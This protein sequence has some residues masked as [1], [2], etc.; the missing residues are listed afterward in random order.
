MVFFR[1][2]DVSAA[3]P[4]PEPITCPCYNPPINLRNRLRR[5]FKLFRRRSLRSIVRGGLR[6][7]FGKRGQRRVYGW[8]MLYKLRYEML[9][10][11]KAPM[12]QW[13]RFYR[14]RVWVDREVFP[15]IESLLLRAKHSVFIQMFIWKD[16]RVGRS[17]AETL[18]W[19]ADRGVSVNI[20]KE[21]VGDFFEL[22]R[23][24]FTTKESTNPLWRRFW[25]HPRIRITHAGDNDHAKV[26]IIDDRIFLLTGMNIADEYHDRLHDYMVEIR[27]QPIVEHYLSDG[28]TPVPQSPVRLVMN[29]RKNE[30]RGEVM[31]LLRSAR[32]SIVVEHCYFSDP[33]VIAALAEKTKNGVDVTLILPSQVD[34]HYHTNMN[35]AGNLMAESDKR[36]LSVFLYPGMFH[37]KV[38]LVDHGKAFL[39][40]A[41]LMESSLDQMGEV[42]VLLEGASS[43]A[44]VKLRDVLR[45]DILQSQ[46]LG[47]YPR[48]LWLRRILAWAKL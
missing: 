38:I 40:S 10:Y 4:Y 35:A 37:G 1:G 45:D 27:G 48:F 11:G 14:T 16:D 8:R 19:I 42:N 26:Y 25:S 44:L 17:M 23:D 39:G 34:L 6:Y 18:L 9:L 15:R 41:N 12:E 13:S 22:H 28:E 30:L 36:R 46:P 43:R 29:G 7:I 31:K 20:R 32:H 47:R 5:A 24:F 3:R 2:T 21:A 33:E